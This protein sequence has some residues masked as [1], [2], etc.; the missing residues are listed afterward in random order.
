MIGFCVVFGLR[1]CV[2]LLFLLIFFV[3]NVDLRNEMYNDIYRL[4]VET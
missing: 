2:Y 4:G 3:A 1:G